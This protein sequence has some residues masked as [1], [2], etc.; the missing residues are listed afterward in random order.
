MNVY[1]CTFQIS[2]LK[3]ENSTLL[4]IK[5]SNEKLERETFDLKSRISQLQ[6]ELLESQSSNS[7]NS[8]PVTTANAVAGDNGVKNNQQEEIDSAQGQVRALFNGLL[9]I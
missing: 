1:V 4:A 6:K 2:N 3:N 7:V 9:L 8:N 5:S